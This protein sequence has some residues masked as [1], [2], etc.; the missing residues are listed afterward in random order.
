M[1]QSELSPLRIRLEHALLALGELDDDTGTHIRHDVRGLLGVI[2]LV[3]DTPGAATAERISGVMSRGHAL[4]A[5]VR[6]YADVTGLYLPSG[7]MSE[8]VVLTSAEILRALAEMEPG[9]TEPPTALQDVIAEAQLAHDTIPSPAMDQN[10]DTT[11]TNW[12]EFDGSN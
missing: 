3:I 2:G 12:R 6:A 9:A 8:T 11:P 1:P 5:R 4:I 10:A 7:T